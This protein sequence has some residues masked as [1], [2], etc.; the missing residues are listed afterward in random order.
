MVWWGVDGERLGVGLFVVM[1]QKVRFI[2]ETDDAP[3]FSR[4]S[5]LMPSKDFNISF[6]PHLFMTLSPVAHAFALG[7]INDAPKVVMWKICVRGD[8]IHH[9]EMI[10]IWI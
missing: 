2:A 6:S 5:E 7:F 9:L 3:N 8:I 10:E 1:M 4:K